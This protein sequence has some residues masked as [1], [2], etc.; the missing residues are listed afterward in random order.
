MPTNYVSGGYGGQ[1][2]SI[3][4]FSDTWGRIK[5]NFNGTTAANQFTAEQAALTR[6]FNSAEAAKQRA[7]EE[8][9]S[10]TAYQRQVADLK[11]AGLNPAIALGSGGASTPSGYSASANSASSVGTGHSGSILGMIG[12]IAKTALSIALFKKFGHT[13]VA[14]KDAPAAVGATSHELKRVYD[15]IA[16]QREMKES[17][18]AIKAADKHFERY[19]D[20]DLIRIAKTPWVNKD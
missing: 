11:A 6:E 9:M 3:G 10:N 2:G 5:N 20:A 17:L 14:A 1:D 19:S 18:S 7:F 13:A 12:S 4:T 8:R 16:E 15:E